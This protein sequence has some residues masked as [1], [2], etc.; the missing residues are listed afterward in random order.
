MY[1]HFEVASGRGG[2][3]EYSGAKA[4]VSEYS[5]PFTD[6]TKRCANSLVVLHPR[7][8]LR[9]AQDIV[10]SRLIQRV[11]SRVVYSPILTQAKA[12]CNSVTASRIS[13]NN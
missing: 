7:A 3:V 11:S 2:D 12:T 4:D 8:S 9:N 6:K 13:R 1:H 10:V 5:G